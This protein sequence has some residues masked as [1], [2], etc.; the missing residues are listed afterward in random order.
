MVFTSVLSAALFASAVAAHGAVTSYVIGG[1][2]YPG[3]GST[4]SPDYCFPCPFGD[5]SLI[6]KLQ[7]HGIQPFVVPPVDPAPVAQL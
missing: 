5:H 2:T 1:T 4:T 6:P 7:V 3:Y